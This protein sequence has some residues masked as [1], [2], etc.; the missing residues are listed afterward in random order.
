MRAHFYGHRQFPV[1]AL[2]SSQLEDQAMT[3]AVPVIAIDGPG[4]SGKGTI[5]LMVAKALKFHFLDSG[6]LYR[7]VALAAK[8]HGI[9]TDNEEALT[10]LAGHMDIAFGAGK[11]GEPRVYLEGEDVSNDIRTDEVSQMASQVA[12]SG[13]VRE[14]LLA[15]QRDFRREPGLVADG[16]DMG[17]IVFPEAEV[18]IFLTASAEKRA[19]RRFKQLQGMGE[20][21][22]IGDLLTSIRS[23][24]ERDRNRSVAP[25]RPADD[26]IEVDSSELNIEQVLESVLQVVRDKL[27][28]LK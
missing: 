20:S 9:S 26:A 18:K 6:A 22:S 19:E 10:V 7:L 17:T 12:A 28:H 13:S 16:R 14:A 3:K 8:H 21:A 4:G 27:P 2:A 1:G 24:D 11:H 23:R 5:G 25:L 15:R